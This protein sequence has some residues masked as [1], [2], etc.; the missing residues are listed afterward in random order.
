LHSFPFFPFLFPFPCYLVSLS[1]IASY[2][3]IRFCCAKDPER[4]A[5]PFVRTRIRL[6]AVTCCQI[7]PVFPKIAAAWRSRWETE[8]IDC[9]KG[10]V[11]WALD[12]SRR[13][14][15]IA[16]WCDC[17]TNRV[18][19]NQCP[20]WNAHQQTTRAY[21]LADSTNINWSDRRRRRCW[22][23]RW[24]YTTD[25]LSSDYK[26]AEKCLHR[27]L[28]S[29]Y[30]PRRSSP[31]IQ[32]SKTTLSARS[33]V[34]CTIYRDWSRRTG[35]SAG[36]RHIT[37]CYWDSNIVVDADAWKSLAKRVSIDYPPGSTKANFSAATLWWRL[38]DCTIR[39]VSIE[40]P[41][42]PRTYSAR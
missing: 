2:V 5:F 21:C 4:K 18:S 24:Y 29:D 25:Q 1:I 17:S 26:D 12:G 40:C 15:V 31:R 36:N 20:C 33:S 42:N 34:L 8:W 32:G 7:N 9:S 30:R 39:P 10:R 16:D 3:P 13:P 41:P 22:C 6:H 38:V 37:D 11:V 28:L 27:S 23:V 14:L 19:P 35:I